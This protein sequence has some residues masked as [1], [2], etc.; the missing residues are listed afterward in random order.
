M[1]INTT[2]KI[3]LDV[4]LTGS[5]VANLQRELSALAKAMEV[6]GGN[7]SFAAYSSQLNKIT[8]Q[9]AGL[10]SKVS[11]ALQP[12][13][14]TSPIKGATEALDLYEGAINGIYTA[15]GRVAKHNV[16]DPL[17]GQFTNA[18]KQA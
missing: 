15:E 7:E 17:T 14:N 18:T 5:G 11:S 1:A 16:R 12:K 9:L 6:A 2:A 3:T 13:V 4:E 8:E 10:S